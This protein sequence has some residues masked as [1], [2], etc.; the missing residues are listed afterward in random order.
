[1]SARALILALIMCFASAPAFA[2]NFSVTSVA[3]VSLGNVAAASSGDTRFRAA[4]TGGSL[5]KISGSG[6][7]VSSFTA[8]VLVTVACANQPACDTDG[9]LIA[10]TQT[11]TPSNRAYAL[12]NFTASAI[13]GT[14]T[15]T[16]TPTTGNSISFTIGPVGRQGSKTFYLGYDFIV[17]GDLSGAP[18]GPSSA[19]LSVTVSRTN[20]NSP[21]SGSGT[22]SAAVFRILD[23][24]SSGVLAF[25]TVSRP[26]TGSGSVSIAPGATS[27]SVTGDGVRSVPGSA[28]ST[29]SVGVTGEGGQNFTVTVPGTFPMTGPGGTVTVTT[30]PDKSGPQTL[31]GSLG[32]PGAL[33]VQIGGTLPLTSATGLGLYTGTFSVL[34]QY[35]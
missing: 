4:A 20:G 17:K 2:Q 34:V 35:N 8:R 31:S 6:A 28:P 24:T 18:S 5:S 26:A 16:N 19:G 29:V 7:A 1:M 9:A 11:G 14:A 22:V 33:T 15:I 21:S 30:I 13:G 23:A 32:G 25:G 3:D 10:V 12:E 27:V